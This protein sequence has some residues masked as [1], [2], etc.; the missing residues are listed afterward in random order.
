M[1]IAVIPARGGSKRIARKNIKDFCGQPMLAYAIEAAQKSQCFDRIIVSTDDE[2]IANV[3]KEYGAEV[4]FLR[5][6]HLADDYTGTTAVVQD[7][8]KRLSEQTRPIDYCCCIYATAPL[9]QAE[10][11]VKS[12]QTLQQD[13]ALDF[14]FSATR[15]SFPIQRA[16]VQTPTGHVQ[17]YSQEHLSMRSQDLTE[18]FHDAAQFYWGRTSA[19]LHPQAQV[20]SERSKMQVLPQHLVQDIDTEEDWLRAEFLFKALKA[21]RR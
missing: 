7:C 4:P 8:L 17:A 18:T 19:W 6:P 11:L 5:A 21:S 15:F 20:F 9:L 3:A 10:F 1:N 16:L 14:V 2:E 13:P 12:Y